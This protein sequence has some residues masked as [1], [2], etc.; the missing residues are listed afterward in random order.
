MKRTSFTL[1]HD[2]VADRMTSNSKPFSHTTLHSVLK[3]VCPLLL[4]AVL[5]CLPQ[6]MFAQKG[7]SIEDVFRQ[8]GKKKNVVMVNMSGE[9]LKDYDFSL[10]RSITIKEDPAA[11]KFVR[12]CLAK[13]EKGAKKIKQVVANGVTTSIFLQLPPMEGG[14][15]LIL[16]NEQFKPSRQ[17]V[18]IYI[19]SE[20]ESEDVLRLLL[21]KGS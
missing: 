11:A 6:D 10:F 16:F 18:L 2:A 8:Y 20:N 15:R 13:D 12:E 7:L 19:E 9:V 14:N 17:L 1:A 4:L 21:K 5:L 3:R